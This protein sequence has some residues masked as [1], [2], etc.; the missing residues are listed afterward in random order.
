LS[1]NALTGSIPKE[2][3]NLCNL[4]ELYILADER[5]LHQNSLTGMIPKEMGNLS[6]LQ[7]LYFLVNKHFVE[8]SVPRINSK[9]NRKA[10]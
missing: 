8:Q 10:M 1:E 7:G 5:N 9:R 4:E 6:N 2:L 3:G